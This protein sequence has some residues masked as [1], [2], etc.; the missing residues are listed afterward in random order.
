MR[1]WKMSGLLRRRNDGRVE[2]R[3]GC[4]SGDDNADQAVSDTCGP[5]LKPYA[6]QCNKPLSQVDAVGR[7]KG[8]DRRGRVGRRAQT[9]AKVRD[10]GRMMEDGATAK[11]MDETKAP[12][13][14][15]ALPLASV[16]DFSESFL[17]SGFWRLVSLLHAHQSG[18]L[19]TSP[20]P[21]T[22]AAFKHCCII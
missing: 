20:L 6:R 21:A 5:G 13:V 8:C 19:V 3:S 4:S 18:L 7:A 11:K 14:Q 10:E 2:V 16:V 9:V 22:E 1:E 17:I 12:Q 15:R